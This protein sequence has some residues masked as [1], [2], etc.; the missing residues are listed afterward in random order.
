MA[1]SRSVHER[2]DELEEKVEKLLNPNTED[3]AEDNDSDKEGE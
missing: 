1:D 3:E 2:L